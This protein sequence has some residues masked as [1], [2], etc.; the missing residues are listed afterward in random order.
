MIF[1]G[2]IFVIALS[3]ARYRA[4]PPSSLA[5]RTKGPGAI[6]EVAC[7]VWSAVADSPL[8]RDRLS[9]GDG[10]LAGPGDGGRQTGR[11]RLPLRAGPAHTAAEGG[12]VRPPR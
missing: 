1:G 6:S 3:S 4:G 12:Q 8:Q 2:G 10:L 11:P 7:S 5:T 9:A